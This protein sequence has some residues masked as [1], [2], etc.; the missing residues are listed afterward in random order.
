MLFGLRWWCCAEQL[1]TK[2]Q[3]LGAF[4][5]GQEAE[6]TDAHKTFGKD[7]Q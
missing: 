5:V 6:V 2:W 4:A 1:Q 7:M 3:E